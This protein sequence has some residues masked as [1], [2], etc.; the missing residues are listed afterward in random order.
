M[1]YNIEFYAHLPK[2]QKYFFLRVQV[3]SGFYFLSSFVF[4]PLR[5]KNIFITILFFNPSPPP[6]L[7][8]N[9]QIKNVP[10]FYVSS[11]NSV[12]TSTQ[13]ISRAAYRTKITDITKIEQYLIPLQADLAHL[14]E[15]DKSAGGGDHDLASVLDVSELGALRGTTEHAGVLDPAALSKLLGCLLDLLG[16]LS[17]K[18]VGL[19]RIILDQIFLEMFLSVLI[20]NHLDQESNMYK[21]S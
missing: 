15:V 19:R 6:P 11:Q 9:I 14:E 8:H 7:D 16:Q 5:V 2:I 10:R 21:P 17:T 20:C 4:L 13:A 18:E 12:I 3:G 1:G